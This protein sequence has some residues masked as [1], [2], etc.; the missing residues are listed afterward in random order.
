M[1]VQAQRARVNWD[2]LRHTLFVLPAN[3]GEAVRAGQ[4]LQA[5]PAPHMH[6]SQ[7][8]WGAVLDKEM[9]AL[10]A[11][12]T[13]AIKTVCVVEMP[14]QELDATG[15]LCS[16]QELQARGLQVDIID[17]HRYDWIDRTHPLSSLEQLCAKINWQLSEFDLHIAINDRAWI[18]GLLAHGLTL[19]QI[20]A[21]R[22][23]DLQAQGHKADKIAAHTQAAQRWLEAGNVQAQAGV[24]VLTKSRINS[25]ILSQE[26]ALRHK[27]GLVNIF[28]GRKRKFH[29]SGQPAV[30]EVLLAINY[31]ALGYPVPYVT[32]SGGDARFSQFFGLKSHSAIAPLCHTHVLAKIKQALASA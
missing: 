24:Y 13:P 4:I 18:A 12:L 20:R 23:F 28:E 14:G 27:D 16:E 25:A 22:D 3:D 6:I 19:A 30:V 21:V 17:H 1:N 29:F 10:R 9:P 8:R 7:Q 2:Y 26:L 15:Q 11:K 32:Y 31:R 5:L